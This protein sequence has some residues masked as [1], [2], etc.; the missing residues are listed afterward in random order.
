MSSTVSPGSAYPE[1]DF[2]VTNG[3]VPTVSGTTGDQQNANVA[4]FMQTGTIPQ[5]PSQ[6]VNWTGF[7]TSQIGFGQLDANIRQA[8]KNA[9]ADGFV[10]NYITASG[11]LTVTVQLGST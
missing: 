1:W 6:G 7:L 3:I 5:L 8:L 11:T 10:P 2:V 9:K 4:V